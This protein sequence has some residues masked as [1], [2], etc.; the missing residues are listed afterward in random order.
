MAVIGIGHDVGTDV[1]DVNADVER[2]NAEYG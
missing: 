1:V 2:E